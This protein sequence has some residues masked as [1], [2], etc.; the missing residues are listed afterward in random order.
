MQPPDM[1]KAR[2]C[3]MAWTS[4]EEEP[5]YVFRVD[6]LQDSDESVRR[7]AIMHVSKHKLREYAPIL[8]N[9]LNREPTYANRRHLVRALG[10]LQARAA[11]DNL[12]AILEEEEGNIVGDAAET[13]GKLRAREAKSRLTVLSM[14]HLDWV[15]N[16]ARW[17]LKQLS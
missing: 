17:A 2:S 4:L 16:K 8:E 5:E 12:M 14:S 7:I 11:L 6:D 3:L 10:N 13:L 15:A 1:S 9:Q